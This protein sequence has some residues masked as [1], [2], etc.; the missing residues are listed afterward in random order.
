LRNDLTLEDVDITE[1]AME[2]LTSIDSDAWAHEVDAIAAYFTSLGDSLPK[3]LRD[4]L[5][6][7]K[8]ALK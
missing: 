1:A 3:K 8:T 7:I 5:D 4:R 6:V 2:L